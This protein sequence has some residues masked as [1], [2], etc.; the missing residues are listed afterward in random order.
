MLFVSISF[1]LGGQHKRSFQWNM[2]F[3][4]TT[5]Q[6]N[7]VI[8]YKVRNMAK[9]LLKHHCNFPMLLVQTTKTGHFSLPLW[10]LIGV[11]S[12]FNE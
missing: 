11:L 9:S 8:K 12:E 3:R 6:A 7:C 1:V 10:V 4:N 5:G 2:G